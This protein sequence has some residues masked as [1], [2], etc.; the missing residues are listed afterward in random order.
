MTISKNNFKLLYF[1][2]DTVDLMPLVES[3]VLFL[4]VDVLDQFMMFVSTEE[5]RMSIEM[6]FGVEFVP[7]LWQ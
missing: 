1:W 4:R 2:R 5:D 6:V 7:L 3:L